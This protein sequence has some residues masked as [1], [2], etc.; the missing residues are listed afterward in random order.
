MELSD[1]Q[2][3]RTLL[4]VHCC[5]ERC[6]S[7]WDTSWLVRHK[8]RKKITTTN[9]GSCRSDRFLPSFVYCAIL[10]LQ[11]GVGVLFLHLEFLVQV[12]AICRFSLYS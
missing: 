4:K 10:L 6:L 11:T 8:E 7:V 3:H 12:I 2:R 1:A 9:I 5:T